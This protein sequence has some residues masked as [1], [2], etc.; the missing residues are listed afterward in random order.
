MI[1]HCGSY[2]FAGIKSKFLNK[3][4]VSSALVLCLNN[5]LHCVFT[6]G[7][8]PALIVLGLNLLTLQCVLGVESPQ[9]IFWGLKPKF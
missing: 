1:Y 7:H 6:I 4:F 8:M 2:S 5:S 3:C 9:G